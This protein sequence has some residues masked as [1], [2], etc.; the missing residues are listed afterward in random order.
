M[1]FK[2]TVAV[3]MMSCVQASCVPEFVRELP[4]RFLR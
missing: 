1:H 4:R 2:I 3:D